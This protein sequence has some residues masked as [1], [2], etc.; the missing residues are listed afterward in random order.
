MKEKPDLRCPQKQRYRR[1]PRFSKT[2]AKLAL[3][4]TTELLLA[5]DTIPIAHPIE[6]G[7]IIYNDSLLPQNKEVNSELPFLKK[8]LS[9]TQRQ[10]VR[11]L[12][13]NIAH[14]LVTI[15]VPS[16]KYTY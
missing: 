5:V 1:L 3:M 10:R 13:C 12:I 14:G 16:D 6:H 8:S 9:F 4:L 7:R 11:S 15:E 2:L